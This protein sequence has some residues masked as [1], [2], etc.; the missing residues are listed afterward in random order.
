MTRISRRRSSSCTA[1]ERGG[2]FR[3][4]Y[5]SRYR[6]HS[7]EPVVPVPSRARP[8]D[9]AAGSAHRISDVELASRLSFFLWSSIPDDELL[10]A[11]D[12][13][14]LSSRRRARNAGA[15]HDRRSARGCA[16][17]ELRGQWLQ[18]RN[19]E[20][21]V[22]PDLLLFPDFDDNLRKAFRRET[23][24]L[25]AEVLRERSQ[26]ARA[27]DRNYT[28]VNERLARHYGIPGVHG[29]RFRRSSTPTRIA[30]GCSATAAS[31][32]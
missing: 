25:F 14:P 19:L 12:R 29:A 1:R 18:L 15:A 6:P 30:T 26:R 20:Q 21:R 17:R 31:Y 28:F 3:G 24:L 22:V 9:L 27:A 7:R 32:R 5:Q 23:E 11:R 4:R 2:K 16:R 13:W 8:A 10:D